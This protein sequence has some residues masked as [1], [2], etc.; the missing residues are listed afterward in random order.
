MKH[1]ILVS[2][3][4]S[5]LVSQATLVGRPLVSIS[6]QIGFA[7]P[8]IAGVY[9][10]R[11]YADGGVECIDNKGVL[12]LGGRPSSELLERA[13]NQSRGLRQVPLRSA[14]NAIPCTDAPTTKIMAFTK[15]SSIQIQEEA[16]CI[17]YHRNGVSHLVRLALAVR[18]GC[19]Q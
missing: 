1:F 14:R 7:P 9:Q 19:R 18:Q 16:N 8:E 5:S 4:L 17:S 6:T 13:L 3:A 2:L 15:L 12:T 10:A 11:A